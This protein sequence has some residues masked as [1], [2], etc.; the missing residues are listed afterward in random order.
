MQRQS[1]AYSGVTLAS[2][3]THQSCRTL[4]RTH[5]T[6]STTLWLR[7]RRKLLAKSRSWALER[8]PSL[9]LSRATLFTSLPALESWAQLLSS[10]THS[11]R[12]SPRSTPSRSLCSLK[13]LTTTTADCE[14]AVKL[15]LDQDTE[16]MFKSL[17]FKQDKLIDS[18][19]SKVLTIIMA[20]KILLKTSLL[21]VLFWIKKSELKNEF[22][23]YLSFDFQ[24]I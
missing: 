17:I 3:L 12:G 4:F 14:T 6:R 15:A 20:G 19:N 9:H 21:T 13:T 11:S 2:I 18:Q 5:S 1:A 8:L 10:L 24:K 16:V 22:K 7:S 23:S